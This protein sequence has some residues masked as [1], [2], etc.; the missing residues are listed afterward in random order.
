MNTNDALETAQAF[1]A[2]MIVPVHY[3]G[4]AHFSESRAD[5]ENAFQALGVRPRLRVLEP[6]VATPVPV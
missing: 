6:G 1:P 4:W 5:L 2:A 3:D